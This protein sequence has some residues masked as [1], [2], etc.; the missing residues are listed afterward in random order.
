M[1]FVLTRTDEV[2]EQIFSASKAE[3]ICAN[4]LDSTVMTWKVNMAACKLK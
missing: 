2:L 3:S 4:W 1:L